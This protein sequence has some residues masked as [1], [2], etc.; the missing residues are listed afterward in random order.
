MSWNRRRGGRGSGNYTVNNPQ[1]R[2]SGGGG[3][4]RPTAARWQARPSAEISACSF[5]FSQ[6]GKICQVICITLGALFF[7]VLPNFKD[8]KSFSITLGVALKGSKYK[9][10]CETPQSAIR[11]DYPVRSSTPLHGH[12]ARR[13]GSPLLFCSF[14]I[15]PHSQ[16]VL[17]A[18]ARITAAACAFDLVC[19]L[20]ETILTLLFRLPVWC[21]RPQAVRW[22][23]LP[24]TSGFI[25]TFRFRARIVRTAGVSSCGSVG[26]LGRRF[27]ALLPYI[28]CR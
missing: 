3:A 2:G 7:Q 4:K 24:E 9:Y 16:L 15:F 14:P 22:A 25:P 13:S 21:G 26:G 8:A 17:T 1:T 20:L 12:A 28:F 11:R 19:A 23:K 18:P 27:P 6:V 5:R 10:V